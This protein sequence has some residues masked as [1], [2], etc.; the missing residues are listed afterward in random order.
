MILKKKNKVPAF[1]IKTGLENSTN[2]GDRNAFTLLNCLE[3]SGF[4]HFEELQGYLVKVKTQFWKTV[5]MSDGVSF[6]IY[7][8]TS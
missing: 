4:L 2:L 6:C 3:L 1:R 5:T 8:C 7:F